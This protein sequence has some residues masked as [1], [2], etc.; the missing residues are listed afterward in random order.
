MYFCLNV[1]LLTFLTYTLVILLSAYSRDLS[2]LK[3]GNNLQFTTRYTYGW[4]NLRHLHTSLFFVLGIIFINLRVATK[5][6]LKAKTT[7]DTFGCS[8]IQL[9]ITSFPRCPPH[10]HYSFS[11]NGSVIRTLKKGVTNVCIIWKNRRHKIYTN[12]SS[13]SL[14]MK[15][16]LLLF[17]TE[18]MKPARLL[19]PCKVI[20]M[21]CPQTSVAVNDAPWWQLEGWHSNPQP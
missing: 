8:A 17:A 12:F 15:Y 20:L 10:P 13:A 2:N 11:F 1:D 19:C 14:N 16:W 9:D 3:C 4:Q 5:Q 21:L 7:L 6:T 18:F